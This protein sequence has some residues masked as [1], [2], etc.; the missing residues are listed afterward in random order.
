MS[1]DQMKSDVFV[2]LRF[3][4][5]S[6]S[7]DPAPVSGVQPCVMRGIVQIVHVQSVHVQSVAYQLQSTSCH[8]YGCDKSEISA[9]V[10]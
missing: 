4:A 5:W 6:P 7:P 1:S 8:M 2:P 3:V 10:P 9:W